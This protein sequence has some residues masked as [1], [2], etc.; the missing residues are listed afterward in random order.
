MLATIKYMNFPSPTHILLNDYAFE[1]KR[2]KGEKRL[3]KERNVH[4]RKVYHADSVIG[5]L[6]QRLANFK[7]KKINENTIKVEL[8]N[9][10]DWLNPYSK[11]DFLLMIEE[12]LVKVENWNIKVCYKTW[13]L[14]R[15]SASILFLPTVLDNS[16]CLDLILYLTPKTSDLMHTEYQTNS[17][18]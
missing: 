1:K 10:L 14:K 8:K 3:Q 16:K 18:C 12:K 17:N 5:I 15:L 9:C 11:K 6:K 13:T 2:L 7:F 4:L